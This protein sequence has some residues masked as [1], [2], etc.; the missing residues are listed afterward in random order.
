MIKKCKF[1]NNEF[2]T[3]NQKKRCCSR[4]CENRYRNLNKE[5]KK[6]WK[7]KMNKHWEDPSFKKNF[8]DTMINAN[9]EELRKK[10]SKFHKEYQ[11]REDVK[12]KTSIISKK[13]WKD[14]NYR[15][16]HIQK[17]KQKWQ[18]PEYREK[19]TEIMI[20]RWQDSEYREKMTEIMIEKWQNPEY[21][22]GLSIAHKKWWNTMENKTKMIIIY[23]DP[24]Y[25]RKLSIAIKNL[26]ENPE[27]AS[28]CLYNGFKYKNFELPSGRIIKLQGYE[29]QVLEQLLQTYSEDDILCEVKN[30]NKEIGRIKYM[31]ENNE[32]TYYP[33]F[34]IKSTNTIIEVKSQWTFDLHKEKNIAKEQACIQQGFNFEFIIL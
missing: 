8:S 33:D 29:P 26:W 5:Y 22:K 15:K 4:S 30:I 21:K 1:C 10:K 6:R 23:K 14:D 3:K 20:G 2:E 18:D 24:T 9:N 16:N 25:R 12:K 13:N 19:M 27:Y 34:Y 17:L 7:D 28:K 32:H 11:N 31:F